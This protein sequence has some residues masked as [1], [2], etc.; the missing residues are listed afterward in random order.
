MVIGCGG[1]IAGGNWWRTLSSQT[2]RG[3]VLPAVR[4]P[5]QCCS[6]QK[7][8]RKTCAGAGDAAGS[9]SSCSW[10]HPRAWLNTQGTPLC[11]GRCGGF[12]YSASPAL[13]GPGFLHHNMGTRTSIGLEDCCK[14]GKKESAF[15]SALRKKNL[16]HLSREWGDIYM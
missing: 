2:E 3:P 12:P 14:E 10:G 9:W 6:P 7:C 4:P 11:W 15:Q 5:H 16:F 1:V 13:V 8:R